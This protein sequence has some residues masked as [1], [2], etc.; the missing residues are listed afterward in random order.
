MSSLSIPLSHG[1]YY[2]QT[3]AVLYPEMMC[4]RYS[5]F[6]ASQCQVAVTQGKFR[7]S[8]YHISSLPHVLSSAVDTTKETFTE[9]L[10][11]FMKGQSNKVPDLTK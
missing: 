2:R 3:A 9:G 8:G 11:K 5:I 10:R 1:R 6:I 7:A 4:L